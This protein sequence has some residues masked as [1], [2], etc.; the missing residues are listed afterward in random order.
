MKI[1]AYAICIKDGKWMSKNEIRMLWHPIASVFML[2]V[3]T[4]CEN[5]GIVGLYKLFCDFFLL[6]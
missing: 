6:C 4:S 1:D 5:D 3:N 2:V